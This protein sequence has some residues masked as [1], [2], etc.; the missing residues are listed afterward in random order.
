MEPGS[1]T[2]LF[3]Y[4]YVDPDIMQEQDP[5]KIPVSDRLYMKM[6]LYTDEEIAVRK[7]LE[8][9]RAARKNLDNNTNYDYY[10]APL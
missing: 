5:K 8:K 9:E 1:Q 7:K 4:G 10:Q 2:V 3:V 6:E